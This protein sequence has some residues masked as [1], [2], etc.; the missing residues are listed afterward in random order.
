MRFDTSS[1]VLQMTTSLGRSVQIVEGSCRYSIVLFVNIYSIQYGDMLLCK[2]NAYFQ[3]D[4]LLHA[5][6]AEVQFVRILCTEHYNI[7]ADT[8]Y[9]LKGHAML[10][11]QNACVHRQSYVDKWELYVLYDD[12]CNLN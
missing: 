10:S 9:V 11:G 5:T 4:S 12:P 6:C 2:V 1:M 8:M 7:W 3:L